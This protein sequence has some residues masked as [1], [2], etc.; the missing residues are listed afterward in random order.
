MRYAVAMICAAACAVPV[1]A[2]AK[3]PGP[4]DAI[5]ATNVLYERTQIEDISATMVEE[6][7][8]MIAW[9]KAGTENAAGC[10]LL[11]KVGGT[12]TIVKIGR[13]SLVDATVLQNLG[14]PEA[15]AKALV[16]DVDAPGGSTPSP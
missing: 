7:P 1:A 4:D 11:K 10:A 13:G 6:G 16:T 14:V 5:A 15:T 2:L 3:Y 9:W 12:W 8:Y